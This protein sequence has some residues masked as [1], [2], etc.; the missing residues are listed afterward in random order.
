MELLDQVALVTGAGSGI[1]RAAAL[2]LAG[3]GAHLGLID[4]EKAG[5]E[6]LKEEIEKLGRKALTFK[7]DISKREETEETFKAALDTFGRIDILVN[8]A[9][10]VSRTCVAD[11]S[12][13]IWDRTIDVNLKGVFLCC[14]AV[15]KPMMEQKR[16]RIV[17]F[18]SGRGVNGQKGN[19]DYAA[20]KGGVIAFT[21]SLALEVAPYGINV[22]GIAPGPTDTPMWRKGKEK[23]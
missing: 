5:M 16:G 14:K 9:G 4:M 13:E 8:C 20:S 21:K 7:T 18:V 6:S 10:I 15:L 12:E 17:N 22:N 19:A 11:M 2:G 3:K 1:G 23:E